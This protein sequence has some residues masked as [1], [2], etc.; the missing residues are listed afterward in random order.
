MYFSLKDHSVFVEA[1]GAF[2]LKVLSTVR[3][4]RGNFQ[5]TIFLHLSTSVFNV[6]FVELEQ[7]LSCGGWCITSTDFVSVF[8]WTK[9][10]ISTTF[11]NYKIVRKLKYI[12]DELFQF[13]SIWT[14]WLGTINAWDLLFCN[15]VRQMVIKIIANFTQKCGRE[16]MIANIPCAIEQFARLCISGFGIDFA[17]F[18]VFNDLKL[19]IYPTHNTNSFIRSNLLNNFVA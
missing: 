15:M 6:L 10:L 5:A 14:D 1:L 19:A 3:K 18:A 12:K 8:E 2:Q 13:D 9:F 4:Q 11:P 16:K 17:N 7:R